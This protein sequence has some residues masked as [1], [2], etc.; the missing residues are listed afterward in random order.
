MS[1]FK[2]KLIFQLS[3]EI[4]DGITTPTHTT[5]GTTTLTPRE[6]ESPLETEEKDT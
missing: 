5:S 4:L 1:I 6:V 3:R 2:A